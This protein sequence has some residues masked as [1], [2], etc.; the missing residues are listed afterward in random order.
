MNQGH[1]H[2]QD[3]KEPLFGNTLWSRPQNR[4]L[5]GKLLIVGGHAHSFADV[6]HAY[7]AAITAGAG[8][9]R[10]ILPSSLQKVVGQFFGDVV[11]APSTP[12]GSFSR[13]ALAEMELAAEWADGVLLA[14]DFGHNSETA[15]M[16]GSLV[17]NYHGPLTVAQDSL[18]YFTS[19]A[20]ELLKRPN[21][22]LVI[23][24][25]KLQKLAK[26]NSPEI[27][28]RYGLDLHQAVQTLSEWSKTS[29][30]W[31]ITKHAD[32]FIVAIAGQ[33]STTPAGS[34]EDW[35]TVLPPY[36]IVWLLQQPGRPFDTLTTAVWD[37][38]K[39]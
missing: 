11:F 7:A 25:E 23:N 8:S 1:W 14:G 32:Y 29:K 18:D 26:N 9:I 5:A 39:R 10:V 21:T 19:S 22:L 38:I 24:F 31:L 16:L 20:A 13:Q 12:S 34:S 4:K 15:V 35:Q 36:G 33:V 37:Y 28:I 3:I 6:G 30:P 2:R 17:Q 27:M